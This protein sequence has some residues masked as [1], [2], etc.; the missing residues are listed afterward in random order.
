MFVGAEAYNTAKSAE[1][2][3]FKN[4][5]DAMSRIS[6]PMFELSCL[7]GVQSALESIKYSDEQ[8]IMVTLLTDMLSSYASQALPTIGGQFARTIDN[9]QRNAYYK[10]RNSNLPEV[11]ESFINKSAAKIPFVS[12]M[13]PEKV[14]RWGRTQKYGSVP[15]RVLENFASPGYYSK[16]APTWTDEKIMTI[17]KNTGNKSVIP[18]AADKSF[19]VNG[20]MVYLSP[21][22]YVEYSKTKGQLSYKYVTEFLKI[23]A[24]IDDETKVEI[25]SAI[26]EYSNA[27][28][29]E[30]VSDYE[31]TAKYQKVD[32]A[33]KKGTSPAK[34]YYNYYTKI[35]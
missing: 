12:R 22:E 5:T 26:Y 31:L 23:P 9:T 11:I 2:F 3:S 4:I 15:E 27:K 16:E 35:K 6:E 19:E 25:I 13:L 29:K 28:A 14:D 18:K 30:K 21:D 1:G 33:M 32:D 7:S 8:N 10:D 17:Y 34:Y 24:N 20:E